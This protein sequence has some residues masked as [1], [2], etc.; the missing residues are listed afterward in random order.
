MELS[1]AARNAL[2][3]QR[4]S[5]GVTLANLASEFGVSSSRI[6][7][8]LAKRERNRKIIAWRLEAPLRKVTIRDFAG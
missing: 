5:E 6:R 4:R 3:E 2:I 1:K 7:D 8:I